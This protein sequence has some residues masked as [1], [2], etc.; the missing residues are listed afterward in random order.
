MGSTPTVRNKKINIIDI[1]KNK[2]NRRD[3]KI[4]WVIIKNKKIKIKFKTY[5]QFFLLFLFFC[6]ILTVRSNLFF[7]VLIF[8][9]MVKKRKAAK[10]VVKKAA[11]KTAKKGKK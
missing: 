10:K 2:K 6:I 1:N 7:Y 3:K 4:V 5:P 11:K 8:F 9:K